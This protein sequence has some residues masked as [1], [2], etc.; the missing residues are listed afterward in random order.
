MTGASSG[1]GR[2]VAIEASRHGAR[3]GVLARRADELNHV[4]SELDGE[5]HVAHRFDVSELDA[6][7]AAVRDVANSLGGLHGLVHAAGIH[8]AVPVRALD[9]GYLSNVFNVNVSSALM[10]AKGLRQKGVH[11]PGASMVLMSSATG[12]VGQPGVGAY[13][14]SKGAIISMTKSL[15]LEFVREDIRVNCL[16]PGVVKTPMTDG[17]QM[18]IGGEAFKQVENAHPLGLGTPEDVANAALFLLSEASRWVT[19]TTLTIDGGYT[20]Q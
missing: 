4:L 19:G 14:A 20:A 15:A 3:V 9:A 11:M 16:A 7:P 13:S 1:L 17:L 2:A 8:S 12:L 10:M 5:G 6:I 18:R